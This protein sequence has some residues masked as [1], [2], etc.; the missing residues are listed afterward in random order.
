MLATRPHATRPRS[1]GTALYALYVSGLATTLVGN[2]LIRLGDRGGW[3][4]S[5]AQTVVA[6]LGAAPLMVAAVV[7]WQLLRRDLD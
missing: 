7:F 3:L 5:A 4:P 2:V 1:P 6:V